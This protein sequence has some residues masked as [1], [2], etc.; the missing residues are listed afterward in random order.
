MVM[1]VLLIGVGD[2]CDNDDDGDDYGD[3]GDVDDG[4]AFL[5]SLII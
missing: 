4:N 3:D 5:V 1:T 2:D